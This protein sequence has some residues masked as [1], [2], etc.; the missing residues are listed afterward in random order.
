MQKTILVAL[1]LT[2]SAL[3]AHAQTSDKSFTT[4]FGQPDC[5]EWVRSHRQVDR[6]WL[7]GYLSGMNQIHNATDRKPTDPLDALNS[8]EQAFL[9]MDNWCKANPLKKVGAGAFELFIEL[10]RHR[11]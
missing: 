7:L 3:S 11:R 6:A 4:A 10:M 2:I 1:L 9:W 5:G 8:A